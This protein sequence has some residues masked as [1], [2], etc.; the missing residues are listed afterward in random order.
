M[1]PFERHLL[2]LSSSTALERVISATSHRLLDLPVPF[3]ETLDPLT[4]PAEFLPILAHGQ[5]VDLWREEWPEEKQRWVVDNWYKFEAAK[6]TLGGLEDFVGL[7]D[8]A[9]VHVIIPP[10]DAFWEEDLTLE[11][12]RAFLE[13]FRQLRV[14]PFFPE[15]KHTEDCFPSSDLV[16]DADAYWDDMVLLDEGADNIFRRAA[17]LYDPADGSMTELTFRTTTELVTRETY[18]TY[19]EVV[20]PSKPS[21]GFFWDDCLGAYFLDAD[22]SADRLVYRVATDRSAM[23]ARNRAQINTVAPSLDPINI[24]PELVS[25][26]APLRPGDD[27]YDADSFWDDCYLP[28]N[29]SWRFVYERTFLFEPDRAP[30]GPGGFGGTF[31]DHARLGMPEFQAIAKVDV[32]DTQ[33]VFAFGDGFWGECLPDPDLRKYED[34]LDAADLARAARDQILVDTAIYRPRRVG[35]PIIMGKSRVGDF[36]PDFF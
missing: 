36:V 12:H 11:E 26:T 16:A 33:P 7:V 20:L 18:V 24:D 17:Y 4:T 34:V 10:Q 35:D 29:D 21:E 23:W 22:G 1:I 13:R 30:S 6:G 14:Y 27:C 31:W 28:E 8:A 32:T 3:R 25:E 2:P 5:S 19:D 9:V 15:I